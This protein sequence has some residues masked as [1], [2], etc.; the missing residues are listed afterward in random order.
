MVEQAFVKGNESNPLTKYFRTPAIELKL[1]S[2]GK[3]WKP[4]SIELSDTGEYSVYPMT[5]VDEMTFNNPD[6]LMNGRAV[7]NVVESCIP[8]IKDA[9]EMPTIDLDAVLIAIR[10]AS[11]GE[12]MDFDSVCTECG[13]EN[14]FG[15]D[16]RVLLD[17]PDK[18][19]MF[20]NPYTYGDLTFVFKPQV[21]RTINDLGLETFQTQRMLQIT[22]NEN[23][24]EDQKIEKINEIVSRMTE[25]T[26]DLMC[27]SIVKIIM[28]DG[29]E[30]EK[31]EYINEFIHN[32][33]R[34][35]YKFI[36]STL[37][38]FG[39]EMG[40]DDIEATCASCNKTYKTP[41]T[42]NNANFFE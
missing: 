24:T 40:A 4:G 12:T 15:L 9:W 3:F 5:A 17:K 28:A 18:S 11:Y 23:L 16:L 32:C 7:V 1:P 21:Y 34:K 22:S 8:A 37:D 35:T 6:A 19:H 29:T 39:E 14:S 41:W 42:F 31:K 27:N 13:E 38:M 25:Y 30:V 20:E 26:I 33:D 10:I 2:G 36:K